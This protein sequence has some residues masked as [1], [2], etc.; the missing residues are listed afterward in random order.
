M[1]TEL[2]ILEHAESY[3]RKLSFGINPL[4]DMSLN[5]NDSCSQERIQKCLRYVADYLSYNITRKQRRMEKRSV[6]QLISIPAEIVE[7]YE[8]F[9][10]PVSISKIVGRLNSSLPKGMSHFLYK[11]IAGF[12]TMDKI[13]APVETSLGRV[14][15]LPTTFGEKVGFVKQKTVFNNIEHERTLCNR[16][17]QHYIL[18]NIQKCIEIA[19]ER[20]RAKNAFESSISVEKNPFIITETLFKQFQQ[21]ARSL[22]IS[23]IAAKLNNLAIT[24]GLF[25]QK[26]SYKEIRDWFTQEGF[27]SKTK[28]SEGKESYTPTEKGSNYGIYFDERVG[29]KGNTY[30]VLMY[31]VDAQIEFLRNTMS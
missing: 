14:T 12:L 30:Q 25:N 13:L 5:E 28:S 18:E 3:L 6:K 8:M 29:S 26:I 22:T 16:L 11:D 20:I 27:L 10:E 24:N 7:K 21:D 31:S 1:A 19:N 2:E 9:N 15:N 17:G 4:T 23:N